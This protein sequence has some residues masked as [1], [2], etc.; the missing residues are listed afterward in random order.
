MAYTKKHQRFDLFKPAHEGSR[1]HVKVLPSC[2]FSKK[3]HEGYWKSGDT[4]DTPP[5]AMESSLCP[6]ARP[7]K[8]GSVSI[9]S[10]QDQNLCADDSLEPFRLRG[11]YP[12]GDSNTIYTW[13]KIA[14]TGD[15]CSKQKTVIENDHWTCK[16][17]SGFIAETH[18]CSEFL[19]PVTLI[20]SISR[21]SKWHWWDL[22]LQ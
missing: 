12:L 1:K 5:S 10:C 11:K 3:V 8:R 21:F 19:R 22:C 9:I 18:L 17:V 20:K 13:A 6:Q 2:V 16:T 7:G 14:L 15:E 4:K